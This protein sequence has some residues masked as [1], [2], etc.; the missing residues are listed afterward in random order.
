MTANNAT[1]L[2]EAFN[3]AAKA[4]NP[5]A[6][7][8]PD[9]LKAVNLLVDA[10]KAFAAANTGDQTI[11]L[12]GDVSG[13]GTGEITAVIGAGK[14]LPTMLSSSILKQLV[15][16]GADASVEAA[17]ATLTGALVGDVVV[18]VVN[19]TDL[20]DASDVF[21]GAITVEDEIQQASTDLSAKKL[22][23]LLIAKGA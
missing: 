13:T 6:V 8:G 5:L 16:T 3:D 20:T 12:S 17:A 1:D 11:T 18:G 21:E 4:I 10:L 22:F 2:R 9:T 7:N 23:I 19:L 14:V 15:F